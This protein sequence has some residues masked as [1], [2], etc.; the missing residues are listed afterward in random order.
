MVSIVP[1]IDRAAAPT[2]R[3]ILFYLYRDDKYCTAGNIKPYGLNLLHLPFQLGCSRVFEESRR[4]L[5]S[6]F[7]DHRDG[8]VTFGA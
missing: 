3:P 5:R 7:P 6:Q 4:Y 8:S 2:A 1:V